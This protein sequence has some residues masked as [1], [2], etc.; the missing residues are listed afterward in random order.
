MYY[1]K[2]TDK[3]GI[4]H[5]AQ[6]IHVYK[7]LTLKLELFL[8]NDIENALKTDNIQ[9]IYSLYNSITQLWEQRNEYDIKVLKHGEE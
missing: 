8:C 4:V 1:I 6:Q 7:S 9:T 2:L 3:N 5:Y